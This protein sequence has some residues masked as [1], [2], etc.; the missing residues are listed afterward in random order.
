MNKYHYVL[1]FFSFEDQE[2]HFD[3]VFID[4]DLAK[5]ACRIKDDHERNGYWHVVCYEWNDLL[6]EYKPVKGDK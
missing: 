2:D 1:F 3:S 6:Q 4:E 5:L